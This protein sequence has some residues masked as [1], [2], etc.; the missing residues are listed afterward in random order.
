MIGK[1]REFDMLSA[2]KSGTE[3]SYITFAG[4]GEIVEFTHSVTMAS[5]A[6]VSIG[7]DLDGGMAWG[8]DAG[9]DVSVIGITVGAEMNNEWENGEQRG[10]SRSKTTSNARAA[11]VSYALGDPNPGDKFV[12]EVIDNKVFGTPFFNTV[13]ASLCS[14][15]SIYRLDH[16]VFVCVQVA[17]AVVLT[18]LTPHRAREES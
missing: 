10:E 11:T 7:L 17:Q 6:S 5:T 15:C 13:G 8:V 16:S 14:F 18:S 2:Q 4:G 3:A 1:M 12:V 9:V